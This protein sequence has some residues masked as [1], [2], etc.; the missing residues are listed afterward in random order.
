[1]VRNR[2]LTMAGIA[3]LVLHLGVA[4]AGLSTTQGDVFGQGGTGPAG[5]STRPVTGRPQDPGSTPAATQAAPAAFPQDLSWLQRYPQLAVLVLGKDPVYE[6][7][8]NDPQGRSYDWHKAD[9]ERRFPIGSAIAADDPWAHRLTVDGK[10][11]LFYDLGRRYGPGHGWVWWKEGVGWVRLTDEAPRGMPPEVVDWHKNRVREQLPPI[12]DRSTRSPIRLAGSQTG[13]PVT[14]SLN[15]G[16]TR[17]ADGTV[18][19]MG[20]H[21]R[22]QGG[23]QTFYERAVW[24]PGL[25]RWTYLNMVG[26]L[27]D[28]RQWRADTAWYEDT[29]Q[30]P[31]VRFVTR[32]R[33]GFDWTAPAPG[34]AP[35]PTGTTPT[36]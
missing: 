15:S 35:R 2:Y 16:G 34:A 21:D 10:Q 20:G 14:Q 7:F 26:T 33:D 36:S 19:Y 6:V 30:G 4:R 18:V 13:T 24:D 27:P 5:A 12:R 25:R 32:G 28:G 8:V 31:R 9:L 1:M 29:P 3:S 17:M 11:I 22:Y 23:G